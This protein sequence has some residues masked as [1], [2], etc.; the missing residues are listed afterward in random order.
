MVLSFSE[1]YFFV[2]NDDLPFLFLYSSLIL[3][4]TF[5]PSPP[6]THLHFSSHPDLLLSHFSSEKSKASPSAPV[7]SANH[8]NLVQWK[9][10]GTYEGGPR[11][12]LAMEDI[13]PEPVHQ[14]I[15]IYTNL[16]SNH[17]CYLWSK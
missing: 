5:P 15:Q 1:T 13:E 9:L 2:F 17:M 7:I 8:N 14:F 3:I 4:K 6:L 16:S 10:S 11:G 12:M